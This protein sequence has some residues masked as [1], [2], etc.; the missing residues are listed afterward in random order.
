MVVIV[1]AVVYLGLMY[2]GKVTTPSFLQPPPE[3]SG[4]S[5]PTADKSHEFNET[6]GE[7]ADA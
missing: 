4:F 2:N 6:D 1:G 5:N 3:G 7:S